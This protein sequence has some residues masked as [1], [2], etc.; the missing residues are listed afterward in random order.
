MRLVLKQ[1][2]GETK[3][4]QFQD[5]PIKIGRAV[6][7]HVFL[8]DRTVSKQHATIRRS[9]DGHWTVEDN[10]SANKTCLNGEAIHKARLKTGDSIRITDFTLE[11]NL[12]DK[13]EAHAPELEDTLN[14][15]AGF[16]SHLLVE[17]SNEVVLIKYFHT[18]VEGFVVFISILDCNNI[19]S[20]KR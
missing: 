6:E 3:E 13:V 16:Q 5:G 1:K 10:D 8:P 15:E 4:Y 2:D 19:I 11:V 20:N 18:F 9:D 17:R 7:N 12:E 14:L